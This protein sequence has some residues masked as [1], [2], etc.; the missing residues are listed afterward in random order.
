MLGI[1]ASLLG[2]APPKRP[3][4]KRA[5]WP[6]RPLTNAELMK[7]INDRP[8]PIHGRSGPPFLSGEPPRGGGVRR[9]RCVGGAGNPPIFR[10]WSERGGICPSISLLYSNKIRLSP[11]VSWRLT[12]HI[13]TQ[14][15]S[16]KTPLYL[17]IASRPPLFHWAAWQSMRRH[18]LS[19]VPAMDCFVASAPRKDGTR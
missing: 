16:P 15:R 13:Q 2:E 9:G 10:K 12:P 18:K 19:R 17:V 8:G 11:C 3:R 5:P 6:W 14:R 1:E 4:R 7:V